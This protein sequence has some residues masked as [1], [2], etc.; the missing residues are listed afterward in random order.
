M[1]GDQVMGRQ[2]ARVA[3]IRKINSNALYEVTSTADKHLTSRGRDGV[4]RTLTQ[5]SSQKLLRRPWCRTG[6]AIQGHTLGENLYI[7]DSNA[8]LISA[9]WMRT[10]ITRCRTLDITL[11]THDDAMRMSKFRVEKRIEA[12]RAADNAADRQR[13]EKYFVSADW[14]F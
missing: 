6:H 9:R 3:G 12:H 8:R 1:V 2:F 7:H 5:N 4:D 11:V 13:E 14:A 10:A